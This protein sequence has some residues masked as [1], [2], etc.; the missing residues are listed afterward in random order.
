M[1]GMCI[2][3]GNETCHCHKHKHQYDALWKQS[4]N[5]GLVKSRVLSAYLAAGYERTT[6]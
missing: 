4:S 3:A 2:D 1:T 5:I 6:N